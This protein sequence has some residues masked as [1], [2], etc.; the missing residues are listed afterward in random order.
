MVQDDNNNN[1]NNDSNNGYFD[2]N[3][4]DNKNRK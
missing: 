3:T 2:K 1:N 4:G